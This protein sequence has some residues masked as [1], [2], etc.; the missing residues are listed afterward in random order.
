MLTFILGALVATIALSLTPEERRNK[1]FNYF[2]LS[3]K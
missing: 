1:I 3:K 2:D